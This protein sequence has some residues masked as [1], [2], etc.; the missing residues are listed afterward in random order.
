MAAGKTFCGRILAEKICKTFVDIDQEIEN[1]TEMKISEIFSNHG[2]IY[3]RKIE[4]ETF[5]SIINKNPVDLIIA[6][7]GGLVIN[8]D[9]YRGIKKCNN[10]FLDED[11]KVI[12]KRLKSSKLKRPKIAGLTIEE[13]KKIF[14]ER[15]KKYY[16]LADY[17]VKNCNELIELMQNLKIME[18]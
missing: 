18:E 4:S 2:E 7:G 1:K 11:F 15:R 17:T 14:E 5:L 3:F 12:I 9:N 13:I 6:S 8:N 16:H 10:I